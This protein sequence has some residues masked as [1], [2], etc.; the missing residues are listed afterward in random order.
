MTLSTTVSRTSYMG[1]GS[2]GPFAVPFRFLDSA[3]LLVTKRSSIGV[4]TI[5]T[6]TTHYTVSG[7]LDATGSITLVTAL[8]VGE[9]LFIRRKPA[10]TQP[11]SI[12]NQGTYFP[13]TIEDEFDRMAM[14]ILALQDSLDR[15]V[16]LKETINGSASLVELEPTAG[17]VVTGT[18]TGFTMSTL[19]SSAVAL[20]GEGRSVSTLSAYLANNSVYNVLDYNTVAADFG[21]KVNFILAQVA[22]K[23]AVIVVPNGSITF[24]TAIDA[25]DSRAIRITSNAGNP[26]SVTDWGPNLIWTGGAGSGSA[27]KAIGSI[28]FEFDHINL[29]Y[30]NAAYDGKLL[31]LSSVG[32][33]QNTSTPHVHHCRISG[34]PTAKLAAMLIELNTTLGFTMDNVTMDYAVIGVGCSGSSNNVIDIGK[35]C[36]LEKHFSDCA[37]KGWGHGWTIGAIVH[38]CDPTAGVPLTPLFK[39]A[40]DSS[41]LRF[42]GGMSVDGGNGGGTIIDL[43]TGG[44]AVSGVDISMV[45]AHGSG[46]GVKCSNTAGKTLGLNVHGCRIDI[47][48]AGCSRGSS[49]EIERRQG[50]RQ[51]VGLPDPVD[52]HGT[53]EIRRVVQ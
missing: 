42:A 23:A 19:D 53:N 9:T 34:T 4:E 18:G 11:M 15:S 39:L 47:V 24:S 27:V 45:I 43:D 49:R 10:N 41:G 5:L 52:R 33:A 26:N 51:Q 20:P 40:G 14:Q 36:W 29:S 48:A 12:R 28:A 32:G 22:K 6:L 7:A 17:K 37:I 2:T 46:T 50:E 38:E 44:F 1:A 3:D 25:T 21:A 35:G 8:A 31:S 30:N 16:K 13:A